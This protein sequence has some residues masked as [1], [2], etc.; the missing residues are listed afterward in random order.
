MSRASR[1]G[2]LKGSQMTKIETVL[3][4]IRAIEAATLTTDPVA[5]LLSREAYALERVYA[6][7]AW[8]ESWKSYGATRELRERQEE[9]IFLRL[10]LE[11]FDV[12]APL[13][14]PHPPPGG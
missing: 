2:I 5:Y 7:E 8:N 9:L 6:C 3:E 11:L 10:A 12:I 4:A 14:A 13:L 1:R